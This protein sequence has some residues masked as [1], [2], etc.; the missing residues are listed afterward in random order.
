LKKVGS[1]GG[2]LVFNRLL[3]TFAYGQHDDHRS[4]A[5]DDPQGGEYASHA[6]SEY[7]PETGL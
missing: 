7:G 3:G 5:D 1:H 4:Y 6:V 2:Y